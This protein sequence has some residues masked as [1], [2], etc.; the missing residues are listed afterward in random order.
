MRSTFLSIDGEDLTGLPLL[1]RKRRLLRIMPF[2]ESRLMYLDHSR[3][4]VATYSASH[5]SVTSRASLR[6]GPKARTAATAA[7]RPG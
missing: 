3:S 4:A 6:S 2:I 1:E 5:A 7:P